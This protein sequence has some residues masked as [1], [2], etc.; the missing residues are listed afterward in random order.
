[1]SNTFLW[2]KNYS[3]GIDL[4]DSQHKTLMELTDNFVLGCIEATSG[5]I[6]PYFK[7]QITAILD[8]LVLHFRMEEQLLS[9]LKFPAAA[10]HR[11]GHA[12]CMGEIYYWLNEINS[13]KSQVIL[14]FTRYLRERIFDHVTG[15][16][17]GYGRYI[18]H[19]KRRGFQIPR[20]ECAL[21]GT[22]NEV[23]R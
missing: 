2:T 12:R 9:I 21:A 19:L 5:D 23:Y 18:L 16:D 3:V 22:E 20:S 8:Y 17:Q 14:S 13:L 11:R 7:K 15:E 6:K 4:L 10:A 1:M